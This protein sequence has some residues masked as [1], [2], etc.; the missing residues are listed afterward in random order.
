M[1]S[2]STRPSAAPCLPNP[3]AAQDPDW[4]MFSEFLRAHGICQL[5]NEA[6][7]AYQMNVSGPYLAAS[8]L[9]HCLT[10][11]HFGI[12]SEYAD[13]ADDRYGRALADYNYEASLEELDR[14]FSTSGYRF[15][16]PS[17]VY[18]GIGYEPFYDILRLDS[19]TPGRVVQ[20]HGF[21]STSVCREKAES[22]SRRDGCMLLE[23]SNIH[24]VDAIVP[25]NAYVPNSPSPSI[26]EQEILLNRGSAFTVVENSEDQAGCR[27]LR[28]EAS[29]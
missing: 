15:A 3:L 14:L 13:L 5:R 7:Q 9:N 25:C 10:L 1:S 17:I 21:L 6:L 27:V 16:P 18:K 12:R 24:H 19:S 8:Q 29:P 4:T 26:P 28:L 20:F 2:F 11:R 22:F 23:I